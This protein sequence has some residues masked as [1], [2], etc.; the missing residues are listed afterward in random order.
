MNDKRTR[1]RHQTDAEFLSNIEILTNT[2]GVLSN[3]DLLKNNSTSTSESDFN[4]NLLTD[5]QSLKDAC[6]QADDKLIQ[7]MRVAA[8]CSMDWNS[9]KYTQDDRIRFCNQCQLNVYNL[10]E[11]STQEA[12][13]LLRENEGKICMRLYRRRD[14]TVITDN[15]PVGLRK[16]RDKARQLVAA[17]IAAFTWFGLPAPSNASP[18]HGKRSLMSERVEVTMGGG[19]IGPIGSD[20]T[21]ITGFKTAGVVRKREPDNIPLIPAIVLSLAG[22]LASGLLLR[23]L[24]V[25]RK[26]SIWALGGAAATVM[27]AAGI[28]WGVFG[29]GL[30]H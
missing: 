22:V 30:I 21:V 29:F 20:A 8:P 27:I 16:M 26:A 9:M 24:A 11:M 23:K 7:S 2:A 1:V 13:S 18:D 3:I 4:S 14:G 15:C 28:A 25:K 12:A 6:S 10:S 5:T 19:T 17:A